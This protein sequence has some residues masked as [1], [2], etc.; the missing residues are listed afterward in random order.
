MEIAMRLRIVATL[1]FLAGPNLLAQTQP[2]VPGPPAAP[3]IQA[4]PRDNQPAS[5]TG[6]AV[7]KGRIIAADTQRP[8]RRAHVLLAP[9]ESG[10]QRREVSTDTDGHYEI[11]NVAPGRYSVTA[12][13][14]G[15]LQLRYGQRRPLEAGKPLI[16][17]N[18]Q[19]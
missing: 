18:G 14:N 6:T 11:A 9:A 7:I 5:P 2:A 12:S 15:Y 13:R 10:L 17:A 8:L 16:L 1:L 4:P 19:I 3:S